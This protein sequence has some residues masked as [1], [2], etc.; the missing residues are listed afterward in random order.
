MSVQVIAVSPCLADQSLIRLPVRSG[1][2]D[3]TSA[4]ATYRPTSEKVSSPQGDRHHRHRRK[5]TRAGAKIGRGA[6]E[7]FARLP[8][9]AVCRGGGGGHRRGDRGPAAGCLHPCRD[10][11]AGGG[12]LRR[13]RQRSLRPDGAVELLRPSASLNSYLM[14]PTADA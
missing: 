9:R 13:A 3:P 14:I 8:E 12:S 1:S 11:G 4:Q 7:D 5:E 10:A 2:S 6:A